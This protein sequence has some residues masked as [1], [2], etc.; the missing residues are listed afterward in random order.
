[1]PLA[2]L[3][4]SHL[5]GNQIQDIALPTD[6]G[7]Y[8]PSENRSLIHLL[9][10]DFT[11]LQAKDSAM[12]IRILI[13]KQHMHERR[14]VALSSRRHCRHGQKP[15]KRSSLGV[16]ILAPYL[17][18]QLYAVSIVQQLQH[19][20]STTSPSNSITEVKE[21]HNRL[22]HSKA[23]LHS[24]SLRQTREKL[25]QKSVCQTTRS[26]HQSA[27]RCLSTLKPGGGE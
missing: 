27:Q 22:G 5:I 14:T 10:R 1:M 23:P 8:G 13:L 25:F 20:R 7:A 15:T 17:H 4:R 26:P 21:L 2:Y 18:Q 9:L 19:S 3:G 16:L 12:G 6:T 11:R 24:R